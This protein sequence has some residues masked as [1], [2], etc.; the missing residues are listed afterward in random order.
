M[1]PYALLAAIPLLATGCWPAAPDDWVA[2]EGAVV[3]RTRAQRGDT[4]V[5][6][7]EG[8]ARTFYD[9]MAGSEERCAE[10]P[11]HCR[12]RGEDLICSTENLRDPYVCEL[13]IEDGVFVAPRGDWELYHSAEANRRFGMATLASGAITFEGDAAGAL[14]ELDI[15]GIE[16]SLPE[17]AVSVL[18][19]P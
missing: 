9:E 3:V 4:F 8:L 2:D 13:H 15:V 6:L 10:A 17:G 11:D 18:D 5:K 12:R 14:G 7:K 16:V 1:R 19:V